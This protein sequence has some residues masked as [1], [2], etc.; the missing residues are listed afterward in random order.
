MTLLSIIV[1]SY[2][3]ILL[4][5]GGAALALF[6]LG[7]YFI[8]KMYR[9]SKAQASSMVLNLTAQPTGSVLPDTAHDV[10]AIAGDD[11]MAT[12]LDLARAYIETGKNQF[13]KLILA[14]VI[15]EG[16]SP[17]QEEAKK[18]LSSI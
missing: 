2:Y 9:P 16:S 11:P 3:S 5:I 10:S 1:K 13:A 17:H 8:Y 15:R 4:Y 6:L 18:L 7:L 12:Q 14:A